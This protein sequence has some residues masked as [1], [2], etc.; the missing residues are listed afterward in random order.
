MIEL[1]W[2]GDDRNQ[3]LFAGSNETELVW[4]EK[5]HRHWSAAVWL[6]GIDRGREYNTLEAHKANIEMKVQHWFARANGEWPPLV[7][8]VQAA[9]PFGSQNDG[10]VRPSDQQEND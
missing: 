5:R 2:E 6:P 4:L 7:A 3:Y 8:P 1:R 9:V 10:K